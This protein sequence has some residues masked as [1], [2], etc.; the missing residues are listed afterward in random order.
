MTSVNQSYQF[1]PSLSAYLA[2]QDTAR[3]QPR[4]L[5]SGLLRESGQIEQLSSDQ[6]SSLQS[7]YYKAQEDIGR[8]RYPDGLPEL[9]PQYGE[10]PSQ[11]SITSLD[12]KK[13]RS[14]RLKTD[15]CCMKPEEATDEISKTIAEFSKK[16]NTVVIRDKDWYKQHNTSKIKTGEYIFNCE[17]FSSS[18]PLRSGHEKQLYEKIKNYIKNKNN[19]IT[20]PEKKITPEMIMEWSLEV[21]SKDGKVSLQDALLTCHNVMRIMA[22][23]ESANPENLK[24]GDPVKYIYD[25]MNAP[26]KHSYGSKEKVSESDPSKMALFNILKEKYKDKG[27]SQKDSQLGTGGNLFDPTNKFSPFK[28]YTNEKVSSAGSAYH[29]WVGAL[30]SATISPGESNTAVLGEGIVVKGLTDGAWKL[31]FDEIPWG[32]QGSKIIKN[33]GLY[34]EYYESWTHDTGNYPQK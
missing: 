19:D 4:D 10:L 28:A 21:N 26:R 32:L 27:I 18:E 8:I 15:K 22:R 14:A 24:D 29:L 7:F 13:V 25:D 34:P 20:K 2:P 31:A 33:T 11:G 3:T 30:M 9:K 5:S 6:I 23:P 17:G 1:D 12:D 16:N